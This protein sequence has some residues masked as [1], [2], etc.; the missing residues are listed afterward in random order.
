MKS[1][2]C[3]L[4]KLSLRKNGKLDGPRA[5]SSSIDLSFWKDRSIQGRPIN[6]YYFSFCFWSSLQAACVPEQGVEQILPSFNGGNDS[7]SSVG[8]NTR[9]R[10]S[11]PLS[12]R[13]Y[14]LDSISAGQ[15]DVIIIQPSHIDLICA[16]NHLTRLSLLLRKHD[17]FF[18]LRMWENMML[19]HWLGHRSWMHACTLSIPWILF[20]IC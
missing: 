18:F 14:Y 1:W 7:E 5:D 16:F 13:I 10:H 6:N 4:W 12:T 15:P 17:A 9:E 8:G 2:V 11:T 20:Q 19:N 3:R